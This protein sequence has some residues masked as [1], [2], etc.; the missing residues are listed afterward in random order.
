MNKANLEV[1]EQKF[2]HI[3]EK[4]KL[5]NPLDINQDQI[6]Y[7]IFDKDEV[8]L[9]AVGELIEE[10]KIIF[11]Y[12][13]GQGL[14][15][16]DLLEEFPDRWLFIY[17]PDIASFSR[18]ISEYDISLLLSHPNLYWIS[19]GDDQLRMLFQ[20][21]CSYMQE[22]LAFIGLR[23]FLEEHIEVLQD[24]RKDFLTF[25]SDY[26]SNKYVENRFR[27]EWTQ[28]Y[29]YHL[30][31]SLTT[32]SI[33]KMFGAFKG[34]TA[35]I[36]SSGPSLTED[37]DWIRKMS[38]HALIIAAGSSVQA[39]VKHGIKPHLCVIMDGHEVNNKIFSNDET[40]KPTLL[41]TSSSYYGISERKG[42]DKIYSIMENDQIS[43]YFLQINK[44]NILMRPTPTVAGTAIQ[45]AIFLGATK[46]VFAGQDLSYPGQKV[47]SDGVEH[48]SQ[49][50]KVKML[51]RAVKQIKNVQ[52]GM[53]STDASFMSMKESIESLIKYFNHI[54]FNNSSSLG[55][56]IEGAPFQP[57]EEIY[58]GLDKGKMVEQNIIENWINDHPIVISH[59]RYANVK[60]KIELVI[61]D[62]NQLSPEIRSIRKLLLTIEELS[63]NK[64]LKCHNVIFDIEQKWGEIVNREWFAPIFE[65]LIPLQIARF[66]RMLP[67]IVVE[68]NIIIKAGYV[69]EYIGEMLDE[70]EKKLPHLEELLLE[71]AR[72]INSIHSIMDA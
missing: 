64:P 60:A 29:L 26:H 2:P 13:F 61:N 38:R 19:V 20:L 40:L 66:D 14:S 43:Q 23:K 22:N 63:R 37:I 28:N 16:A 35:I 62:V 55:A 72:R 21:L 33:E 42:K 46:V 10:S 18:V 48:F 12:G 4:M 67:S 17:E 58:G 52:G 32:H 54:E 9:Q 45:T 1:L 69:K 68:Q 71:S 44:S 70:I 57:I 41:F 7:E 3:A 56:V 5:S 49:D 15:I 25:K 50:T 51:Q 27:N 11:V 30:H 36:V 53:N 6:M 47:Y 31:E 39:L 34:I 24:V 65:S 8:W 59:E